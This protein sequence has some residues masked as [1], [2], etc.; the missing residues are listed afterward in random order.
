MEDSPYKSPEIETFQDSSPE[1]TPGLDREKVIRVAKFQRWVILAVLAN[2][3]L[4]ILVLVMGRQPFPVSLVVPAVA[5]PVVVF[6]IASIFMLTQQ[7]KNAGLAVLCSVLMFV[8]CVSLIVLLVVNQMATSFPKA[9]GIRVGFFGA[10]AS[11]I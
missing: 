2:I 5:L 8:P 6:M 4:Y 11:S 9:N 3:G 10:D 1:K 7:L